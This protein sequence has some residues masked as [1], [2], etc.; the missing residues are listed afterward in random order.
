MVVCFICAQVL[1]NLLSNA[2]KFTERG[3]IT[4]TWT[5]VDEMIQPAGLEDADVADNSCVLT[6]E[7]CNSVWI[8]YSLCISSFNSELRTS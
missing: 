6:N 4:I 8:I 7:V 3:G 2:I 5:R 1:T